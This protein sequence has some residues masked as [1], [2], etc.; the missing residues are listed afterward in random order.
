MHGNV[1]DLEQFGPE[2][3]ERIRQNLPAGV[4]RDIE[5]AR[6]LAWLPL[7]HDLRLSSAVSGVVGRQRHHDWARSSMGRSLQSPLLQPLWQGAFRLFGMS[8]G[9]LFRAVPSGWQAVY[10]DVGS[11][12]LLA[13]PDQARLTIT[14]ITDALVASPAYLEALCGTFAA[15]LDTA[16]TPGVVEVVDFDPKARRIEYVARWGKALRDAR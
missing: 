2:T 8:P 5:N 12:S 9:A 4:L 3:S 16:R 13:E 10:R 15:L 6:R 14:E 11:P 7:E 1:A